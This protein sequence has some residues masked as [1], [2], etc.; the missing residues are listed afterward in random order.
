MLGADLDSVGLVI[1][2]KDSLLYFVVDLSGCV[3]EGLLD[4]GGR[5]GRGLHEDEAVLPGERLALLP[6]DIAAGFKITF[7]ADEHDDHV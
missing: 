1:D 2:I 3:D 5:L 7:V 4:V 6:L